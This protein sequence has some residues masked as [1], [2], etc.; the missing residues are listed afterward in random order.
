[1]C[2]CS[3]LLHWDVAPAPLG[4]FLPR[5]FETCDPGWEAAA[6]EHTH[7]YSLPFLEG[8]CMGS[9]GVSCPS[10]EAPR[11]VK[12]LT[13]QHAEKLHPRCRL[14]CIMTDA[15]RASSE[16]P[17][18]LFSTPKQ[19]FYFSGAGAVLQD[20]K[21]DDKKHG[22]KDEKKDEKKS[23]HASHASHAARGRAAGAAGGAAAAATAVMDKARPPPPH[24]QRNEDTRWTLNGFS[25]SSVL[26]E[27]LPVSRGRLPLN[28]CVAAYS[29]ASSIEPL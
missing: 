21:E 13:L 26:R 8:R 22:K 6:G 3:E 29:C 27:L 11:A 2:S 23:S 12:H 25:C 7:L 16:E 19:R 5:V 14:T 10:S 18:V 4:K 1:L 24:T 15:L 20:K 17:R 9:L 28:Q